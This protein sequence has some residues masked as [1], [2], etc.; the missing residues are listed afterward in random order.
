MICVHQV[1][2][3]RTQCSHGLCAGGKVYRRGM[4]AGTCGVVGSWSQQSGAIAHS[5]SLE[6][7]L[8]T[9]IL[10]VEVRVMPLR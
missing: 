5:E 9:L 4:A 8:Q 7:P 2:Q 10:Q 3:I 1:P 6:K